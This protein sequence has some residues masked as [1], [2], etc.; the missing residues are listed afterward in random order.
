MTTHLPGRLAGASEGIIEEIQLRVPLEHYSYR[1][2][3][4]GTRVLV[5]RILV[6][7]TRI[8]IPSRRVDDRGPSWSLRSQHIG[9]GGAR[10]GPPHILT[11]RLIHLAMNFVGVADE[12]PC[13]LYTSPSPRD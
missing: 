12:V 7:K 3:G 11:P 9:S 2:Y 6:G 1:Y 4:T 5:F 8:A 10:H 13:L